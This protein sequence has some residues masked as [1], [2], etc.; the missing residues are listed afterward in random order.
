MAIL[1]LLPDRLKSHVLAAFERAESL[2]DVAYFRSLLGFRG[3]QSCCSQRA[4]LEIRAVLSVMAT[5]G[6]SMSA[7]FELK[8]SLKAMSRG[9]LQSFL[10]SL[11]EGP[12]PSLK[13]LTCLSE[14]R[15]K[16]TDLTSALSKYNRSVV[17]SPSLTLSPGEVLYD[18]PISDSL[19]V[20]VMIYG[21]A[22]GH[23]ALYDEHGRWRWRRIRQ[24]YVF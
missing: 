1:D 18:G 15:L 12:Q 22:A 5:C 23:A 11:T 13:L 21:D 24:K 16:A 4:R 20:R 9:D 6:M 8:E 3:V 7:A 17:S 2:E 14:N 19:S 10:R